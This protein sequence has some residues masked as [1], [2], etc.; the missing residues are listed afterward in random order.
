M[1]IKGA[2]SRRLALFGAP[3]LALV[4]GTS[5]LTPS[6]VSSAAVARAGSSH[7]CPDGQMP[8]SDALS[9]AG[10][11]LRCVAAI[12]PETFEEMNAKLGQAQARSAAPFRTVAQGAYA[13]AVAQGRTALPAGTYSGSGSTW[14]A[15]GQSPYRADDATYPNVVPLGFKGLSGRITAFAYDPAVA[16]H[17]WA[18]PA[19]GGVWETTNSG[20]LWH[21]IGDNLPTQ[22]MGAI[23]YNRYTHRLFAG[24]G[25][26]AFGGDSSFGLGLFYSDSDGANWVHVASI[27]G[28]S[29]LFKVAVS[30][31]DATGMTV[32]A[33]T[34]RGLFKSTTDGTT[35]TNVAL[36]TTDATY[37]VLDQ[38]PQ[39]PTFNTQVHCAGRTDVPLCFFASIVTDVVV[40][41]I[42][43]G[44]SAPAGAVMAAVGWRAG[45]RVNKDAAGSPVMLCQMPAGTAVACIQAPQ[46]GLYI[47]PSGDPGTFAYQSHPSP[48]PNW[49]LG[50][51]FAPN[52]HVGRTTLAIATG[53]GQN[54]DDVYALVQ[55]A[56]L[57]QGCLSDP[58]D[59]QN[60]CQST[61]TGLTVATYLDGA[62]VSHDFGKTWTKI[63][64]SAQLKA[65]GN[66]SLIGQA[67]YTP[68][69]QSWYNNWIEPDPTVT[70]GGDPGRVVFGLEEIWENNVNVPT[71]L[72]QSYQVP[73]NKGV[74]PL[75]PWIVIGRYWDACAGVS[76]PVNAPCSPTLQSSPTEGSTTHPDQHAHAL[77]PDGNGGVT[78]LAGSDG[79][80]F[81][82][83][84]ARGAD[85]SNDNWAEG[86]NG[87]LHTL[88]PYDAEIS[89]DGTIYAGLQD[90]G[91]DKITP[92]GRQR[93]IFGGDAFFS[94]TD[95][96]KPNNV[97][98]EYTYAG[99][100]LS[101]DG[102]K[103]WTTISPTDVTG[104]MN[105]CDST[106]SQ[107]STPIEQDPTMPGH[108]LVG[109]G[110]L[111]EATNAYAMACVD[112][113]CQVTQSPFTTTYD[114]GALPNGAIKVPSALGVR[115]EHEY[116]G[117]CGYCDIVTGK[118][119][120]DSGIVTNVGGTA[121]PKIG[122]S[123]GWHAAGARC[124]PDCGTSDG[125]LPKRFI[126]SIQ[127]DPGDANTVYVTLGGYGRRW[128]PPGSLGDPVDNVGNGHVFVSHDH[129]EHFADISGNLPDDPA[130]WTV[131]HNGQL[132]VATDAG[133]FIARDTNGGTWGVLGA[134]LPAAP[135]FTL[136][137]QPGNTDRMIAATYGRGV[138]QYCFAAA[139]ANAAPPI[140]G[141]N[142]ASTITT[143]PNTAAGGP[144]WPLVPTGV[145]V[146]A[147][148]AILARR[149][150]LSR[151]T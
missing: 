67:G 143:L 98:E 145:V 29:L 122:S 13:A 24:T 44:S 10:A 78:L 47:S 61:V 42:A 140:V 91:E 129:G 74:G 92:D 130:N 70:V 14:Q 57:F 128:I 101:N 69:I 5:S 88:Q 139:C 114:L 136:R 68:G 105:T 58:L 100:S 135:V 127:Q 18:A 53:A 20:A 52:D 72:T 99:L 55:D 86:I 51:D 148:A 106:N 107:F 30:D 62:Y 147:T 76:L 132:V 3:M 41:K 33:A 94:V 75:S 31:A 118:L 48:D 63:M 22:E 6:A 146:A 34:S 141:P 89:R 59:I 151:P 131:V 27:P 40:K 126:T 85:F 104:Q 2:F 26:N 124:V 38:N 120:F 64:D 144:L 113:L 125:K 97:I 43:S 115:G 28:T 149:W 4:F 116:V 65:G 56:I 95:P 21:S 110:K 93:E 37:T 82:Q 137:L 121:A 79:G 102:G 25:D 50:T 109:C 36:P 11:S 133:V 23:T 123:D 80:A 108:V 111:Q 66:T 134:S 119:P 39:S 81:L 77:I 138:Y 9:A 32:Y 35:F 16:G 103:T 60:A 45:N 7:G 117:W 84:V 142:T 49:A 8:E 1:K 19:A 90:N 83:H 96:A 46:N 112:P 71:A 73:T 54:N 150:R 12:H 17:F 15:V 87:G